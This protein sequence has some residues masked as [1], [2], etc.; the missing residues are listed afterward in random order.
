MWYF[1]MDDFLSFGMFS[2]LIYLIECISTLFLF[3]EEYSI[4]SIGHILLSIH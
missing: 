2:R 4:A 1:V 3:T